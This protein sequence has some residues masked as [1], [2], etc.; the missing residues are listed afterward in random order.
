[1]KKIKIANYNFALIIGLCIVAL[2]F[3]DWSPKPVELK[4]GTWRAVIQRPDGKQIV[5]NFQSKDSAGKKIIYVINGKEHLLVDSIE[6]SADSIFI[7][8][9]F[10]ESGF[11][12]KINNEGNL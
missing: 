4:N 9:P 5:F 7:Q 11:R 3:V 8:M 2:L 12:A 10:F 1:M 6:A